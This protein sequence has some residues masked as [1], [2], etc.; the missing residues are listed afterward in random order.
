MYILQIFLFLMS[1]GVICSRE[2]G[3]FQLYT[4]PF[5]RGSVQSLHSFLLLLQNFL[6]CP[7]WRH[8]SHK[9]C[10]SF[11]IRNLMFSPPII[12]CKSRMSF[13]NSSSMI[14]GSI[15]LL[16]SFLLGTQIS[17]TDLWQIFFIPFREFCQI[18]IVHCPPLAIVLRP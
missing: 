16:P 4:L 8:L 9:V 5:C 1:C 12:I 7:N 3:H 10:L 2:N 14:E 11:F 15:S 17:T 6:G 18:S 13:S